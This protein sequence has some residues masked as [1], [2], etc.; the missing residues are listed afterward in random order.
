MDGKFNLSRRSI[1]A[2]S[3]VA[4]AGLLAGMVRAGNGPPAVT[5]AATQ[6]LKA[7]GAPMPVAFLMD[8]GITMIDF[9]GPWEVFQD[10]VDGNKQRFSV[11]SVASTSGQLQTTGRVS[12]SDMTGLKYTADYTFDDAPQ[13]KV[14]VIGAQGHGLNPAK[15]DWIRRAAANADVVMS[16]CTG[17]FVLAATG[18]LDGLSAT[19]HHDAYDDFAKRFPKV[20]LVRG[21][22]FVDNGKFV[23]AGGLTSGIDTALHV[24]NRYFG[25]SSTQQV[26][27]Y[28]EYRGGAWRA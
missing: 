9:A 25:A 4:S 3:A 7:D 5:P 6:P 8:E 14:I 19:T 20:N 18:L 11:F 17:A 28:M 27:E 22:R 23:T 10:V 21:T 24:V 12:G 1:I 15:L 16:V 26:A 2:G 13:P